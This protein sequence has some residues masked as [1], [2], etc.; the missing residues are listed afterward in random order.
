M[1]K[2]LLEAKRT[3]NSYRY[4]EDKRSSKSKSVEIDDSYIRSQSYNDGLLISKHFA[5]ELSSA[6]EDV[7]KR[8]KIP[9]ANVEAFVYASPEI[10]AG[11][12]SS[13]GNNC[14]I[15]FSSTL[16]NLLDLDEFAF[17][18][19]H[20]LGHFLF[21]HWQL[22]S[23]T[24]DGSIEH[25]LNQRASEVSAD[26]AGLIACG[27]LQA[28]MRAM[29]KSISGLSSKYLRFDFNSFISMADKTAKNN[30]Y[31]ADSSHPSMISR[32]RALLWFSMDTNLEK[33]S[34]II[35][36]DRID[37][38]D[39]RI[40][41]DMDKYADGPV[42]K[43]INNAKTDLKMWMELKRIIEKGSFK[44]EDQESFE[45][46]FGEELLRKSKIFLESINKSDAPGIILGKI[47][48]AKTSLA[49]V[50]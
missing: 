46:N 3:A 7:Y 5:P 20:E 33:Y 41:R 12:F 17:V 1:D 36:R 47:N 42:R 21:D 4:S 37:K 27:N 39:Q 32:C 50:S 2:K 16:I 14:I 18:A 22:M 11:C 29:M 34:E 44:K 48:Q 24:E 49:E 43:L 10:N 26:R 45:T 31:F 38:L 23:N 6:L 35:N 8:L 19:G 30:F 28:S 13:N 15:K 25:Y 40:M 9:N